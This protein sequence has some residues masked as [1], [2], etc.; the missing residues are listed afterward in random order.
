MSMP[1]PAPRRSET[2]IRITVHFRIVTLFFL[3]YGGG[4]IWRKIVDYQAVLLHKVALPLVTEIKCPCHCLR[5]RQGAPKAANDQVF[6]RL[7]FF[8]I[9]T[10]CDVSAV[11]I[12][13][14]VLF[15]GTSSR[16]R[17]KMS[18][19]PPA[20]KTRRTKTEN[21]QVF[22]RLY[23]FRILTLS[24]VS[25]VI[26]CVMYPSCAHQHQKMTLLGRDNT[27]EGGVICQKVVD[28]HA[29]LI[30]KVTLPLVTGVKCPYHCL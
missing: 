26:K 19:P 5:P 3:Q 30:H 18:M 15:S 22:A 28:Y 20:T 25:A 1:P 11:V 21:D 7:R 29:V 16:H 24:Y 17:S 27:A 2:A 13:C 8:R 6:V 10:L 12:K 4:V 23:F 14:T 9:L